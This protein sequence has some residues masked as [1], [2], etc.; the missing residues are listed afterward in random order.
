MK[1]NDSHLNNAN[2]LHEAPVGH[3]MG[4]I[5]PTPVYKFL[6]WLAVLMVFTYVLVYGIIKWNDAR[7]DKMNG[8]V[9]HMPKSKSEQLPPEPRLQL[10]PG[11]AIHPLAEGIAYRDS[12][13]QYLA[14]YAYLNKSTGSVRIPIDRAK[15]I[16]L[17]H[18]VAVRASAASTIPALMQPEFS[19]AGRMTIARDQ[20]VPGGTFTVTGGAPQS[21]ENAAE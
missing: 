14:S 20:R 19:S 18:G 17:Q 12:V 6:G 3:E 4:D 9:T 7:M 13:Y 1:E 5:N 16:F 8:I 21:K 15:E 11:H 10:A 2:N